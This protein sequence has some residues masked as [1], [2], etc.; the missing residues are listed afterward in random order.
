MFAKQVKQLFRIKMNKITELT[1]ENNKEVT[2][3]WKRGVKPENNGSFD[4]VVIGQD[5]WGAFSDAS[6]IEIHCT[7][8]VKKNN[9]YKEKPIL[10]VLEADQRPIGQGVLDL[11]MFADL[12]GRVVDSFIDITTK[13]RIKKARLELQISSEPYESTGNS[14][15]TENFE[16]SRTETDDVFSHVLSAH[17]RAGMGAEPVATKYTQAQVDDLTRG[18]L[19]ELDAKI[20]ETKRQLDIVSVWAEET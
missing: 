3:L 13:K 9:M 17:E 5:K 4:P 14:E 12:N 16:L 10:F 2:C 11:A 15:E 19:D 6:V 20:E 7:L 8:F 18:R 1:I